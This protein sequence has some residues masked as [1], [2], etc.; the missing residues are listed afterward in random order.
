MTIDVVNF[1]VQLLF[2][3]LSVPTEPSFFFILL[4]PRLYHSL[5]ILRR[6]EVL[7]D[8]VTSPEFPG[9]SHLLGV[10]RRTHIPG[11]IRDSEWPSR[12]LAFRSSFGVE[13]YTS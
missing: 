13:V 6:P 1:L 4:T 3:I 12:C 11:S 9:L 10:H 2:L 8:V 7:S 5:A